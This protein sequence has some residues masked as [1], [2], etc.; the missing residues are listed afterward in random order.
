MPISNKSWK[1]FQ[2]KLSWSPICR[3]DW[4]VEKPCTQC[5]SACQ[6]PECQA[7]WLH[8]AKYI[9]DL[10]DDLISFFC[11]LYPL[12]PKTWSKSLT[13][14]ATTILVWGSHR[15]PTL[16]YEYECMCDK[17][18]GIWWFFILFP[19]IPLN[20][21]P[22][23]QWQGLYKLGTCL[24]MNESS[25]AWIGHYGRKA[26]IAPTDSKHAYITAYIAL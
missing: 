25:W 10:Y 9:Y 22:G 1:I 15:R 6:G 3:K 2:K 18:P 20:P 19:Q 11:R 12:P 7:S 14:E 16:D 21:L 13:K 4:H 8:L 5:S 23:R 17:F 24:V 26:R